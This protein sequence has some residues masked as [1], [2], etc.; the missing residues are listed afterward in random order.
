M[1]H[2]IAPARTAAP[3]AAPV[4]S[5][6]LWLDA[7]RVTAGISIICMHAA[8]APDGSPFADATPAAR[9]APVLIRTVFYLARTELF[10]IISLFLL[11]M[12]LH[13]RPRPY[14]T[15]LAEQAQR[16]LVPFLFWVAVY[17]VF[18]LA[19]GYRLGWGHYLLRDL[20]TMVEPWVG[21]LVLG[22]VKQHMHFLPTLFALVAFYPLYRVAV[23]WPALALALVPLLILRQ[24]LS[25]MVWN[26][27]FDPELRQYAL[28]LV[29]ILTYTGY[30]LVAA[31][32]YGVYLRIGAGGQ[33]GSL[34][35][36]R[37]RRLH[38]GLLGSFAMLGIVCL[39]LKLAQAAATIEAGSWQ[40]NYPFA[41]YANLL[42]PVALFGLA[43]L[44]PVP[45][46]RWI[47]RLAPYSFGIFLVHP[48]ALDLF[49]LMF[50]TRIDTPT[51][52]VLAN[53]GFAV[54]LS[55]A[56]AL[57]LARMPALRWTIGLGPAPRPWARAR[58][59]PPVAT[60][61]A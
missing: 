58:A 23:R 44:T 39:Y 59:Q 28:R 35:G 33:S 4:S 36:A 6:S 1:T 42:M 51:L 52:Y 45:W 30:G 57:G 16:L 5:R 21:Y 29:R 26:Q 24:D 25:H 27:I 31:A 40:S 8:N 32:L 38:R 41:G 22:D 13:R 10:L 49:R 55:Y 12:S 20:T 7:L 43:M 46:P 47:G 17:V 11:A 9:A 54:T 48:I 37:R 60:P 19:V 50:E 61:T 53:M 14:A 18:N 3:A 2:A 15:T 34:T 56:L